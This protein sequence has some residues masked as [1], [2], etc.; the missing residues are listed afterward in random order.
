MAYAQ[1]GQDLQRTEEQRRALEI[2]YRREKTISRL[3]ELTTD[4]EPDVESKALDQAQDEEAAAVNAEAAAV[5]ADEIKQAPETVIEQVDQSV[6][7]TTQNE[8]VQS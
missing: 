3:V 8:A 2:S 1:F 4:S 5:I 6:S 7:D